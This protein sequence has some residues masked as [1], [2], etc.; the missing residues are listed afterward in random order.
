ASPT[1]INQFMDLDARI[2]SEIKEALKNYFEHYTPESECGLEVYS[3]SFTLG[4][5]IHSDDFKVERGQ[6]P[7]ELEDTFVSEEK[8]WA[9]TVRSDRDPPGMR[10]F[11]F[12]EFLLTRF[13]EVD[14]QLCA[15][16]QRHEA[17]S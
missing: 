14:E 4:R 9:F 1:L 13:L 8:P 2:Q 16:L 10:H 15:Y 3:L 17:G 11:I 5:L 6:V 7:R 12:I